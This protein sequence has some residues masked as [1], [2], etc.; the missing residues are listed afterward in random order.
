MTDTQAAKL[1]KIIENGCTDSDIEDFCF[2]E[3]VS[4]KEA[5]HIIARLSAPTKCQKCQHVGMY[6]SLPPCSTCIHQDTLTDNF[7]EDPDYKPLPPYK[8]KDWKIG[9]CYSTKTLTDVML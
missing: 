6:D 5:F 3:K 7:K 9:E 4:T 2:K 1:Y 8:T